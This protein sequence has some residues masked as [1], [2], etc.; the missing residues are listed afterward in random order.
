MDSSTPVGTQ[1]AGHGTL[2]PESSAAL[3]LTRAMRDLGVAEFTLDGLHVKL[4][5]FVPSAERA[6]ESGRVNAEKAQSTEDDESAA[7]ALEFRSA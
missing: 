5:P 6:T 7:T 1:S 4:Y 3:A 2:S